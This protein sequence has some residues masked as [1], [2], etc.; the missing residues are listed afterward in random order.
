MSIP[1]IDIERTRTGGDTHVMVRHTNKAKRIA[2]MRALRLNPE[3][4]NHFIAEH[5]GVTG[6]TVAKYRLL[7]ENDGEDRA[8]RFHPTKRIGKD[9]KRYTAY[10]RR[11]KSTAIST[12]VMAPIRCHSRKYAGMSIDPL[13]EARSLFDHCDRIYLDVLVSELRA[14]ING[15][16]V[17]T[18]LPPS[19]RPI[20]CAFPHT[21]RF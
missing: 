1:I 2:V 14:L 15:N 16:V 5:V 20:H 12:N 13:V 18:S 9:G 11:S 8:I 4:S 21:R 17:S 10:K 7:M 19:P 6:V 3:R